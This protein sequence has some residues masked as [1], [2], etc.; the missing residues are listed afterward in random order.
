VD[1]QFHLGDRNNP[2]VVN[3]EVKR[4][5]GDVLRQVRGRN[6]K[7]EWFERFCRQ[8]VLPKYRSSHE[9]EVNVLAISLFGEIGRGVQFVIGEWLMNQDII[10]AVLVTSR[11]ARR[12]RCFDWHFRNGKAVRLKGFLRDPSSE[13]QGLVFMLDVPIDVPG[14][15]AITRV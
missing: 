6:F 9:H 8:S 3:L 1:W 10:D 11:E 5:P 15:P 2:I 4:L 13:E 7:V 14:I 12:C